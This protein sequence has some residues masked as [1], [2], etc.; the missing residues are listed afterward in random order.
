MKFKRLKV[1]LAPSSIHETPVLTV[2]L[3]VDVDGRP[4]M[5]TFQTLFNPEF[6]QSQLDVVWAAMRR[7]FD[8][9]VQQ[10]I[11]GNTECPALPKEKQ[12]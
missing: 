12:P 5:T 10:L 1:E 4:R 8:E 9:A 11:H 3:L 2:D 6:N 7:S